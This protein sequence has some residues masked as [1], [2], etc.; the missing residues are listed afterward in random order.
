MTKCANQS[1]SWPSIP[2]KSPLRPIEHS[3]ANLFRGS[4]I[5]CLHIGFSYRSASRCYVMC[6]SIV[7]F[8][9]LFMEEKD[10]TLR[11]GAG[12]GARSIDGID[13]SS[14]MYGS[15]VFADA[16]NPQCSQP[17]ASDRWRC[18]SLAILHSDQDQR[19]TIHFAT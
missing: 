6:G 13:I 2:S 7:R 3:N 15:M 19:H 11:M 4:L 18:F 1:E 14:N 5:D 8:S 16:K 9:F 10:G 17:S 12:D